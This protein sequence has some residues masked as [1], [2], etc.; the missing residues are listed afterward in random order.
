[1]ED[2]TRALE[3]RMPIALNYWYNHPM[4]L[5]DIG[6]PLWNFRNNSGN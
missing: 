3:N 2:M 5:P 6:H 4:S 1:M